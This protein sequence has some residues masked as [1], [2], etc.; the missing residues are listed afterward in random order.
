MIIYV[1]DS[2][3]IDQVTLM[4]L[5]STCTGYLMWNCG[6]LAFYISAAISP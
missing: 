1:V 2:A 3:A 4:I 5:L 6:L